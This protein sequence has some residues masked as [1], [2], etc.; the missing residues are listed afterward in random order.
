MQVEL[1]PIIKILSE[2]SIAIVIFVIWYFTFQRANKQSDQ[3]LEKHAALSEKLLTLL[4]EEQEYKSLLAGT[5]NRL[6]IMVKRNA[7]CPLLKHPE[8]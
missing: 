1:L 7:S 3:A 6:E 2:S 5:M 8:D 4:G